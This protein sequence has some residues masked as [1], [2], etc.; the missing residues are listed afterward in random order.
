M[1][2][3]CEWEDKNNQKQKSEKI[4]KTKKNVNEKKEDEY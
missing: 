2:W 4:K 1:S 3:W